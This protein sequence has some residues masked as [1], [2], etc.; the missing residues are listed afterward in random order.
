M[1]QP[2]V[3][4]LHFL[5]RTT[6]LASIELIDPQTWTRHHHSRSPTALCPPLVSR[7]H[8]RLSRRYCGLRVPCPRTQTRS[9]GLVTTLFPYVGPFAQVN[10]KTSHTFGVLLGVTGPGSPRQRAE[11]FQTILYRIASLYL[12]SRRISSHTTQPEA[13]FQETSQTKN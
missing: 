4:I 5:C 3:R 6:V 7:N 2:H 13:V 1:T 12:V 11:L 8:N 10:E 9:L